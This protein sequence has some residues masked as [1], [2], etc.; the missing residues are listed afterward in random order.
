MLWVV[1][2]ALAAMLYGWFAAERRWFP[3]AL[4]ADGVKTLRAVADRPTVYRMG[5]LGF[6]GI[7]PGDAPA[8]RVRFLG[9]AATLGGPVLWSGVGSY[10]FRDLCPRTGCAAVAYRADGTVAH[11]YPWRPRE[12]E[13][14]WRAAAAPRLH[15]FQ[16]GYAFAANAHPS[17]VLAYPNGDVSVALKHYNAYPY[18]L[19]VARVDR[20]GMPRW[21]RRDYSHHIGQLDTAG[22]LMT[23]ALTLGE[24]KL[25]V[26]LRGFGCADKNAYWSLIN[27]IDGEGRLTRSMALTRALLD[28]PFAGAVNHTSNPCDPLHANAVHRLGPDAAGAWGIAPGDIVASLRNLSA[29]AVVDA[30]AARLKRLVKGGFH[31]QHGVTH[32]R[33][34]KFLMFDNLGGDGVH[35]PSR[36]LMVDLADGRET[37]VF[38][39]V[40]TP[41]PLRGLHSDVAG[42][43]DISPDGN[44][45]LV[46][47]TRSA[48]AVEIA[49]PSGEA[50]AVLTSLHD[51]SG[52]AAFS[53]ELAKRRLEHAAKARLYN[54]SYIRQS[55]RSD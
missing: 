23:P 11:A 18:P 31:Q 1:A 10:W 27:F 13:R 46:S 52:V 45:A 19:G 28:S 5:L 16:P 37:T 7:A 26:K 39:N 9:D 21:V 41:A 25:P 15:E 42:H 55:A 35:G 54:V 36:V 3:H 20:R 4:F 47:F 17:H 38:P 29:F 49:L 24:A 48:V 34:A 8:Q 40:G 22:G 33:Q 50:L 14:A 51:V 53:G 43:I 44:R 32:Y 12:V 6:A 2:A 30:D